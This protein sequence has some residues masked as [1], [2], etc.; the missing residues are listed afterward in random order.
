MKVLCEKLLEKFDYIVI[1]GPAGIDDGLSIAAGGADMAVIIMSADYA[2]S[3]DGEMVQSVLKEQGIQKIG[4]IVNRL[5]MDMIRKGFA[6]G[7]SE[8]VKGFQ[9]DLLGVI[10]LDENI[11][12]STNLGVPIVFMQGTYIADNFKKISKR[13]KEF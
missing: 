4:F 8:I 11:N 2:S 13:I 1:D 9:K 6:P 5:N 10:Q 7:M 12:I 3:R